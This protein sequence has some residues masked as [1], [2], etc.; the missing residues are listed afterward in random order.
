M[1]LAGLVAQPR[2]SRCR[3]PR[4]AGAR[5]WPSRRGGNG[6]RSATIAAGAAAPARGRSRGT[7]DRQRDLARAVLGRPPRHTGRARCRPSP[8]RARR[9]RPAAGRRRA[10]RPRPSR[11]RRVC[12]VA[13][14]RAVLGRGRRPRR[15]P[16]RVRA[17][18]KQRRHHDVTSG[19]RRS[20]A[21]RSRS[22][23]PPHTPNSVR[24]SRASARH[25]AMTGQLLTDRSWRSAARPP[26][27]Q[28]VRVV[29]DATSL[30]RPVLPA[31]HSGGTRLG[32]TGVPGRPAFDDRH[33]SFPLPLPP[34]TNPDTSSAAVI[35]P[36]ESAETDTRNGS[37]VQ[38]SP[39]RM[40]CRRR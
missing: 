30:A 10:R 33:W 29:A 6:R 4:R 21:R 40:V 9:R 32:D 15:S 14:H 39:A 25:S 27:E 26:H 34:S 23:M 3:R 37:D 12:I 1:P 17:V 31:A 20:M 18:W 8:R 36:S 13:A 19:R 7:A 28:G 16:G 5:P 35:R 2:C 24:L 11:R 38:P 22:V